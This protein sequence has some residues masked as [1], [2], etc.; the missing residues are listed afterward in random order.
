M[1]SGQLL[2]FSVTALA[3]PIAAGPQA[4]QVMVQGMLKRSRYFQDEAGSWEAAEQQFQA[5][6]VAIEEAIELP[7]IGTQGKI[8]ALCPAVSTKAKREV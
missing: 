5:D 8:R 3:L 7:C 4:M 6:L 1:S 2:C